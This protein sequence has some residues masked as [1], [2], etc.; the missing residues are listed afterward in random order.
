MRRN[1]GLPTIAKGG[2]RDVSTLLDADKLYRITFCRRCGVQT[3]HIYCDLLVYSGLGYAC[4]TCGTEQLPTRTDI[5][6][7][8]KSA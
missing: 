4:L 1:D 6:K 7:K 2:P 8:R 5:R 3:Q